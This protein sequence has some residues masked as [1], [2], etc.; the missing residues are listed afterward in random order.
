[1]GS[2]S[3]TILETEDGSCTY[4]AAHSNSL[5]RFI[6]A[7]KVQAGSRLQVYNTSPLN[8]NSD[9]FQ[10]DVSSTVLSMDWA[11]PLF[12]EM[13]AVSLDSDIIEFWGA[14][15]NF[16][17]PGSSPLSN[18]SKLSSINLKT[19]ARSIRFAPSQNGLILAAL[20]DL[21]EIQIFEADQIL[22]PS[23]WT[24]QGIVKTMT[25]EPAT[26][27]CWR[28]AKDL[29]LA[30]G[31]GSQ[32]I[33]YHYDRCVLTWKR[34]AACALETPQHS[35]PV[36]ALQWRHES[37]A[38]TP[39]AAAST[40][41]TSSTPLLSMDRAEMLAVSFGSQV[42]LFQLAGRSTSLTPKVAQILDLPSGESAWKVEW[43]LT[44]GQLAVGTEKAVQ[45]T[46]DFSTNSSFFNGSSNRNSISN[47]KSSTPES[48]VRI[49][50]QSPLGSYLPISTI[51]SA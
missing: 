10:W 3:K 28:P 26:C 31:S 48:A 15:P 4:E 9:T 33:I 25:G 19:R 8:S 18:Y 2:I 49:F 27:F 17:K 46:Q 16:S 47:N 1:M 29:V 24:L 22:A 11:S 13:V 6:T 12:G 50:R 39:A 23:S 14:T 36:R 40:S 5:S 37:S 43:D 7:S 38:V 35:S 30:L 32:A 21:G 44:G 20:T 41:S 42:A 34:V 45:D 51:T